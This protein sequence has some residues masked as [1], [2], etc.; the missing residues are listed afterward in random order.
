MIKQWLLSSLE[1]SNWGNNVFSV[2]TLSWR[3]D[4]CSLRI[5]QNAHSPEMCEL[6]RLKQGSFMKCVR[7][8]ATK[9]LFWVF[10]VLAYPWEITAFKRGTITCMY[11]H[12]LP[13]FP[14]VFLCSL[15]TFLVCIAA[16]DHK[17]PW[18]VSEDLFKCMVMI[19]SRFSE[20]K[21]ANSAGRN[22]LLH[23]CWKLLSGTSKI[24]G[25]PSSATRQHDFWL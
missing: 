1:I 9:S 24:A 23:Q 11:F 4:Y 16:D 6:F 19:S 12:N 2:A 10:L 7:F 3:C 15:T 14:V 8:S 18:H 21:N 20:L 25:K 22:C 13:C 5:L 17:L